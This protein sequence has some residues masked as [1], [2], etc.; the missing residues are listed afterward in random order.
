[1]ARSSSRR[2]LIMSLVTGGRLF[3]LVGAILL[4]RSWGWSGQM[5]CMEGR[6]NLLAA[7]GLW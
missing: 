7:G 5:E 6:M 1:M 3:C 4:V 2:L